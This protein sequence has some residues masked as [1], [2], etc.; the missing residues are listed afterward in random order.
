M[1]VSQYSVP[2]GDDAGM[3]ASV[4]SDL[5]RYMAVLATRNKVPADKIAELATWPDDEIEREAEKVAAILNRFAVAVAEAVDNAA[6]ADNFLRQL[7]LDL[8]ER[9]HNWRDIFRSIRVQK[10]WRAEHKTAAIAAYLDY[11]S[12]RKRLVGYIMTRKASLARTN[13]WMH[14][15]LVPHRIH[16][17]GYVQLKKSEPLSLDVP[18]GGTVEL[19]LASRPFRLIATQPGRLI[20]ED[21]QHYPFKQGKNIIGRHVSADIRLPDRYEDISR[22]HLL[23]QLV[24]GTRLSLTD[25]STGGTFISDRSLGFL[26]SDDAQQEITSAPAR[27]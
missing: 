15:D 6:A 11:L 9:D 19:L 4:P 10:V 3:N 21:G 7:D 8:I 1:N 20:D 12:F 13:S 23:V 2:A 22:A 25:L 27:R 14:D 16:N 18:P 24:R 5:S 17:D 26:L